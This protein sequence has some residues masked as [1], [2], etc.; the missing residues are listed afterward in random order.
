ME[1][2]HEGVVVDVVFKKKRVALKCI[3]GTQKQYCRICSP[4]SFCVHDRRKS[5]CMDC[6][7]GQCLHKKNKRICRVCSPQTFCK[8]DVQKLQCKEC[9][10]DSLCEHGNI[11]HCIHCER[12]RCSH[13]KMKSSCRVCSPNAFCKHGKGRGKCRD[14]H[15]NSF[16]EHSYKKGRCR[17]CSTNSFCEHG[18]EKELCKECGT[19]RCVHNIQ[20]KACRDCSAKTFCVHEVRK[21]SCVEC[22]GASICEH[23]QNRSQCKKC[24]RCY[25]HLCERPVAKSTGR[26]TAYQWQETDNPET[27]TEIYNDLLASALLTKSE[28]NQ[29]DLDR[30]DQEF[31]YDSYIKA[32]E[33]FYTPAGTCFTCARD[34]QRSRF[35]GNERVLHYSLKR[36]GVTLTTVPRT[37]A[38]KKKEMRIMDVLDTNDIPQVNDKVPRTAIPPVSGQIIDLIFK[39]ITLMT[40]SSPST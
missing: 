8:H 34:E 25:V 1:Q 38:R 36:Q 23:S 35:K 15:P 40:S 33:K 12:N 28:F 22:G 11:V 21:A 30:F 26:T 39:S 20:K 29:T 2:S 19:D 13:N 37:G 27:G 10:P 9:S 3:H 5:V 18:R 14:C 32:G 4:N 16:C 17:H 31:F 6:G 7:T 24:P